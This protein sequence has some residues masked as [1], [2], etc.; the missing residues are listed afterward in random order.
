MTRLMIM[1][2]SIFL[3]AALS[4][5]GNSATRND[6][7]KDTT[8]SVLSDAGTVDPVALDREKG[9]TS[10]VLHAASSGMA[11]VNLANLALRQSANAEVKAFAEKMI[12]DHGAANKKLQ[13][14][15]AH[16]QIVLPESLA[17]KHKKIYDDLSSRKA[18]EFD[19]AYANVMVESHREALA[20]MKTGAES[21]EHEDLKQYAKQTTPV[22]SKHL[23]HAQELQRSVR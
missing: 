13:Q 15:A 6:E 2:G 8:D 21:L 7:Q 10:F 16:H 22:I 20:L 1:A 18:A 5:C 11:E 9:D 4:S 14:L 12:A 17:E 23:E 19:L 3:C